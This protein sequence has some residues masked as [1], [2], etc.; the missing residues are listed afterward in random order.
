MRVSDFPE[1]I[2]MG[3][4]KEVSTMTSWALLLQNWNDPVWFILR[5]CEIE[6]G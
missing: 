1:S 4:F 5:H 6:S 3:V 2:T